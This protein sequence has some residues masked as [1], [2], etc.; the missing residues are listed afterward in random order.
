MEKVNLPK[1]TKKIHY[2]IFRGINFTDLLVLLIFISISISI[3]FL[4]SVNVYL[5]F[6]LSL[7]VMALGFISIQKVKNETRTYELI[8]RGIKYLTMIGK[9]SSVNLNPN[10]ELL[11]DKN[12]VLFKYL[13]DNLFICGVELQTVNLTLL[14]ENQQATVLEDF[15]DLLRTITMSCKIIKTNQNY[16]FEEQ[17]NNLKNQKLKKNNDENNY[18]IDLQ[19]E[20]LKSIQETKLLTTPTVYIL[21][22]SDN[23]ERTLSQLQSLITNNS[24][25]SL[26]IKKLSQEIINNIWTDF[27]F[28]EQNIKT[29]YSNFKGK[30]NNGFVW[31]INDLPKQI[32]YFWLNNL[33]N[34]S[35]V[36]ICINLNPINKLKAKKQLDN[37]LNKIKTNE[38]Y[39]LTTSQKTELEQFYNAFLEQ[40]QAVI[41]DVDVLKDTSI[42]IIA[43]GNKTTLNNTKRQLIDLANTMSW[44]YNNLLFLQQQALIEI[45]YWTKFISKE[46]EIEMTCDTF[47]T[48]FPIPD[49]PL[50][51]E[52]GF[53]LA[54]TNSGKPVIWD[55]FKKNSQRINHNLL[56]LGESGSGKS[57]TTKKI[58]LN[59][60]YQNDRKIFILDPE[61]EFS[62]LTKYLN[63]QVVNGSGAKGNIIN[64]LEIY[65]LDD[66]HDNADTFNNQLS[67]LEAFFVMLY[68]N[69]NDDDITTSLLIELIKE[70]YFQNHILPST[71]FEKLK[72]TDYPTFTDLYNYI[73]QKIKDE[74]SSSNILKLDNLKS[75]LTALTQGTYAKYW[76]GH[77][78]FQW[79]KANIVC[80]DLRELFENSNKKIINLQMMMILRMLGIELSATQSYNENKQEKDWKRI[81]IAVDEAHLLANENNSVALDFLFHTMKRIRKCK[82]SLIIATQNIADFTG[83]ENVKKKFTGIINNVQY[84]LVGGMQP[85]DLNNL[86]DMYKQS[87]G[88]SEAIKTYIA[89]AT[90]GKFWFKISKQEQLPIQV[91]QID[92]EVEIVGNT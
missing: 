24:F 41:D 22:C 13:K 16:D 80:F 44:K 12:I 86:N 77:T 33:F 61:R 57:F 43:Y 20:Q 65:K 84:T 87:G 45:Y 46:V 7:I 21:F 82:S 72:A 59:Q 25:S 50:K 6:S 70:L 29:N 9:S 69:L 90:Q 54:E 88:L 53:L 17:I 51:D 19:I 74:K 83:S 23:K 27:T 89:K 26:N 85:N 10:F 36:N 40:Q 81:I 62:N 66:S 5:K 42:F 56:I 55:L 14:N 91:L 71:D 67:L 34:L 48:S 35:N 63:G 79:S 31:A 11:N 4:L 76:N 92:D 30:N 60:A 73:C 3:A 32:N 75:K 64:P 47:A 18:L 15:A 8:V 38:Q 78:K 52:K 49:M 37:A 68:P 28:N 58:I 39:A 2:Q 1:S